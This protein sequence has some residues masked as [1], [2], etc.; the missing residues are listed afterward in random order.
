MFFAPIRAMSSSCRAE[1]PHFST[2]TRESRAARRYEVLSSLPLVSITL[3]TLACSSS[4]ATAPTPAAESH[5]TDTSESASSPADSA[6]LADAGETITAP[7]QPADWSAAV[8]A[9]LAVDES[10]KP[11]VFETHL[12]AA[13]TTVE[14]VPGTTTE[15]WAYNGSLSGPEIRVKRGDRVIIHFTNNLPEP[16]TIHWHGL[17]IP[18]DMDGVPGV[19]QPEVQPGETF[20]YDFTAPDAG[21]YWYHPHVRSAAQAGFGLYGAFVVTDPDEPPDLGDELTLVLSDISLDEDGALQP[22]DISGDLGTLFGREGSH[23]LVNGK[24]DPVLEF[25]A[26]RRQRWRLVNAARSRYFQLQISDHTFTRIGGDSGFIEHPVEGDAI[27]IA[28]GER[29]EVVFEPNATPGTELSVRWVPYDRGFGTVF[30]RPEVT[31]FRMRASDQD[32]YAEKSLPGLSRKITPLDT[33]D[34]KIVTMDLTQNDAADGTFAMGINGVP[35]WDAPP[36]VAE[37][38]ETQIW[39]VRNTID[40]AHP[41]HLHGYFF[42]VLDLNGVAP[43]VREWKDTAD[44]PVDGVL[45]LAVHFDERPGM[46][47][48]HCHILDHADAGMMGMVHVLAPGE[49]PFPD[50]GAPHAH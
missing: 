36:I 5:A 20:T 45:R 31:V 18:N 12:E 46:W 32:P 41:F 11:D 44:V 39:E 24:V 26:G 48:F 30:G 29:S 21:T 9:P 35:S 23:L 6:P 7:A 10:P 43:A 19:S 1:Q 50:G 15:V 42:Q 33:T 22:P 34:A 37:L 47:M 25:R 16:T 13:P 14:I 49:E 40:F 17:R 4:E 8:V 28:P 38:G 3:F 2:L 27:V